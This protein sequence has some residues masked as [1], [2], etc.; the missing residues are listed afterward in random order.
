MTHFKDG[1]EVKQLNLHDVPVKVIEAMKDIRLKKV[2]QGEFKPLTQ[3]EKWTEAAK[4][5]LG[6]KHKI[7]L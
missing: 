5:F 3:P 2:V 4:Y 6:H 1:I 7:K